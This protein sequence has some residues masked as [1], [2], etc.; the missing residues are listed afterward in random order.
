MMGHF[1]QFP[2]PSDNP[3]QEI[4]E[5]AFGSI[6][7]NI[8]EKAKTRP[9]KELSDVFEGLMDHV[10]RME[11]QAEAEACLLLYLFFLCLPVYVCV[12]IVCVFIVHFTCNC[13]LCVFYFCIVFMS[14]LVCIV[15]V[16]IFISWN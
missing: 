5:E 14:F 1:G 12:F 8:K 3:A 16:H 2:L 10:D 13:F 4:Q 15:L 6:W 9:E 11:E 7:K